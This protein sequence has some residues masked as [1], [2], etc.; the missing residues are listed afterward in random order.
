MG[1]T[2]GK[3]ALYTACAGVAPDFCLPIH[4]DVGVNR[5]SIR[6]DPA[7]IG[8]RRERERGPAYDE[9]LEE[10]FEACKKKY[11]RNVLIQFE[12]FGNSNAFRLLEKHQ[13]SSNCFNDDIQGTASVV[14]A[15]I[16]STLGLTKK[17]KLS[18][19]QYLFQGAG[20]AG[21]GIADLLASA[22][23]IEE[24]VS[25]DVARSKIWLVDSKGLLTSDRKDD[26]AHHKKPYAH[27]NP[28]TN[29]IVTLIDAIK[30]LKPSALLG[31]SA[32]AQSFN[33]EV[34]KEMVKNNERPLIFALSNPTSKAE[35]TAKDA[36]TF[37]NGKAV[38]A[39]GSPFDPVTLADGQIFIPGQGN[40]AYI[41]PGIGLG[42][43]ISESTTLNDD[44]FYI[45]A[46]TLASLVSE[47]RLK[48]GCAYPPLD[49]IR[50]VSKQIALAVANNVY[51]TGRSSSKEKK[52]Y[53]KIIKEISY[54]P[55]TV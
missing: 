14:L 13:T 37:S 33:E 16:I 24:N 21:V 15:G 9:L 3:L 31:V 44:D 22:I 27:K 18:D 49:D 8:L 26:L 25:L 47:E 54:D 11:G 5:D 4:I 41:F 48:Q 6:S 34:I 30:V 36:Y 38:F 50:S 19:H 52:D 43:L 20:E 42:S 45:A 39:S 29:N 55:W 53:E 12:D 32:I 10:F 51:V 35:C 40:N 23:S 17:S 28:S 7:Y 1:I 46:K 2:I